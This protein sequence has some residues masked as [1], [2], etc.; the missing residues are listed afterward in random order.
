MEA[1]AMPTLIS[2]DP[3]GTPRPGR[4]SADTWLARARTHAGQKKMARAC[5]ALAYVEAGAITGGECR[6]WTRQVGWEID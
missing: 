3:L 6:Q 2:P 1:P 5:L 4:P